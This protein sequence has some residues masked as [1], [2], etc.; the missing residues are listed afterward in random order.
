MLIENVMY[1]ALG[2]LAAG[3][4][5]L[6]ILPAVW[7]R[8]VRLTKRRIEAA[9]PMTMAEFR[10]DKDQLRAEFA[11]SIRRLELQNDQ[12]RARLATDLG[13]ESRHQDDVNAMRIERAQH[14]EIVAEMEAR[15]QD[16]T[17]RLHEA[18]RDAVD[19]G[20]RLR[21]RERELAAGTDQV[22]ALRASLASELP[23]EANNLTGDYVADLEHIA[24]MLAVERKRAAFLEDQSRSLVARIE[25][26]ERQPAEAA[27][28][29]ASNRAL[30]PTPDER[31]DA[32]PDAQIASAKAQMNAVLAETVGSSALTEGHAQPLL[33]ETLGLEA[34]LAALHRDVSAIET[35]ILAGDGTGAHNEAQLRSRLDAVATSV[36]GLVY[37]LET[38]GSSNADEESLFDKVQR[39]AEDGGNI[40][41]FPLTQSER[42]P[43]QVG[44]GQPRGSQGR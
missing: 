43:A 4:L 38:G 18:E 23:I 29:F 26:A 32:A 36:T 13:D 28:S 16:L 6:A 24:R 41:P 42:D 27:R 8:A 37:A 14:A 12:L 15:Y 44:H 2:L 35:I 20:Q 5:A 3:L 31:Q 7:R 25:A 40:E 30:A 9:T 22:E 19:L 39:F 33:A 34:Q 21:M 1:F 17:A 11:L 10:A